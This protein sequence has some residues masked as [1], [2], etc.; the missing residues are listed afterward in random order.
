ME[1]VL[2]MFFLVFSTVNFQFD[3][4]KLSW[5]SYT[6][7]KALS[8]ISQVEL[9]DKKEVAKAA[10]DKNSKTFVVYIVALEIL[11]FDR[12]IIHLFRLA[13]ALPEVQLVAL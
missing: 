3:A 4:E 13:Q 8:T 12:I 11:K 7:T 2:E 10:L 5:K 6:I 1:V 9:I